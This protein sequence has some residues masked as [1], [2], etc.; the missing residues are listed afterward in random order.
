MNTELLNHANN[1]LGKI[2]NLE[3]SK[4]NVD[5]LIE[6]KAISANFDDEQMNFWIEPKPSSSTAFMPVEVLAYWQKAL[7]TELKVAKETFEKL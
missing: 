3:M 5:E 2:S 4:R 6:Q 7:E 1:L